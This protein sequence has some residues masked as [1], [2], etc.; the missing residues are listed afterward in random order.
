MV[1]VE[2]LSRCPS[3]CIGSVVRRDVM[4]KLV[5]VVIDRALKAFKQKS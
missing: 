2:V 4:S 5:I 1:H 3:L